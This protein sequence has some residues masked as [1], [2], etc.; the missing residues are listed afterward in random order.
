MEDN[1]YYRARL[2]AI[3][4]KINSMPVSTNRFEKGTPLSLLKYGYIHDEI[5]GDIALL[6]VKIKKDSPNTV[7]TFSELTRFS[8]WFAMYPEK[9]CGTQQVTTS[10][11]FPIRIVGDKHTIEKAIND[12][13][14]QESD[15]S[16]D[17]LDLLIN[18]LV[19]HA[20][21]FRV[22]EFTE[23]NCN[24]DFG[25]NLS[26]G[27]TGFIK[28]PIGLVK[29]ELKDIKKLERKNRIKFFGLI[30]PTLE[31]PL[32]IAKSYDKEGKEREAFIKTFI[33]KDTNTIFFVS[34]VKDENEF[35]EIA[36]NYSPRTT[37]IRKILSEGSITYQDNRIMTALL[38]FTDKPK[39]NYT[40]LIIGINLKSIGKDTNNL[41]EKQ[42]K[43]VWQM[44]FDE[45]KDNII[46][47]RVF[48]VSNANSDFKFQGEFKVP[49]KYSNTY[50]T[51]KSKENNLLDAKKDIYNQ[52]IKRTESTP[53][54]EVWEMTV[55]ELINNEIAKAEIFG[56]GTYPKWITDNVEIP[57]S[58]KRT[59]IVYNHYTLFQSNKEGIKH[60]G[61]IAHFN[62]VEKAL[63]EG[64]PVPVEV[65]SDYP[66]LKQTK[67]PP[68]TENEPEIFSA[69]V[70][71]YKADGNTLTDSKIKI[72]KLQK[73]LYITNDPVQ[74]NKYDSSN[75]YYYVIAKFEDNGNVV[76]V[77]QGTYSL[78]I[79]NERLSEINVDEF[80]S[81]HLKLLK[82]NSDV[83]IADGTFINSLTIEL[84][85]RL[86]LPTA[87]LERKRE[88][89]FEL[90][91][92]KEIDREAEKK[93]AIEQK[94]QAE[95]IEL[96]NQKKKLIDGEFVLGEYIISIAKE[97]GID[98]HIRTIGAIRDKNVSF[99]YNKN[100][101]SVSY[102]YHAKKGFKIDVGYVYQIVKKIQGELTSDNSKAKLI[103]L[104]KMKMLKIGFSGIT[105]LLNGYVQTE[106]LSVKSLYK[107]K[108]NPLTIKKIYKKNLIWKSVLNHDKNI[109]IK[110][111]N[112]GLNKSIFGR[113]H[114]KGYIISID[115]Y[116]ATAIH[117]L[118]QM[119]EFAKFEFFG[120]N[121]KP[122]HKKIGGIK[123]W[124]FRSKL[125]I[126]NKLYYF[127][128]PVLE[129]KGK[130]YLQYSIEYAQIKK[131]L[132]G[133]RAKSVKT[134]SQDTRDFRNA[135]IQQK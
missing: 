15:I 128:L 135:K 55:N 50:L 129:V 32:I 67:L 40:T 72:R 58:D 22:M 133:L 126:D 21:P 116:I 23:E 120:Y 118:P 65:L 45:F 111:Q 33:Q 18:E 47:N 42:K 14:K 127:S 63:Q 51:F 89:Y 20:I 134:A 41:P 13:L 48:K 77:W 92:Q 117:Y 130:D 56:Y 106:V 79:I 1:A 80:I 11:E 103:A 12:T 96:E 73:N 76:Y 75:D 78:K 31:A 102:R 90:K 115:I 132:V 122:N 26:S 95:K 57:V 85:K 108:V 109:L 100:D 107:D 131:S 97:Y 99:Q 84:G 24:I 52:I 69:N 105:D 19:N 36:T 64:K 59:G 25:V 38:G 68:E 87:H 86:G 44:T 54:K 7:L 60:W 70:L 93:Q 5:K 74:K 71:R 2:Q 17:K 61:K 39:P 10:F 30:K 62:I 121:L 101:E 6:I 91:K 43:E 112:I 124:N 8:N 53:E 16:T 9:I 28:T 114:Q 81:N 119:L 34:F 37:Q 3:E 35:L 113:K 29:A 98:I 94:K 83:F 46:S 49:S 82:N 27:E 4:A 110:F 88:K 66:E 104:A 125:K 123:F